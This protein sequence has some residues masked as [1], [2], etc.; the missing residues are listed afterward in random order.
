[1][2]TAF[3]AVM[4]SACPTFLE[5]A[6]VMLASV[7]VE[8]GGPVGVYY[9]AVVAK[10]SIPRTGICPTLFSPPQNLLV[11]TLVNSPSPSKFRYSFH[12]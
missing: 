10:L 4:R 12:L 6:D 7:V 5:T 3:S 11:F 8:P 1:M 9:T 2:W